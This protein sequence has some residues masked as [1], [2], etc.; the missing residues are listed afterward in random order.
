MTTFT[1]KLDATDDRIL[2]MGAGNTIMAD[3]GV[4]PRCIEELHRLFEFPEN[5]RLM[6]VGTTGLGIIDDLRQADRIVI[7]DAA[8]D[9]GHPAGTVLL[10]TPQE[11]AANQVMHSAHDMR[12]IDVFKAAAMMGLEFKSV[13]IVA[14]QVESLAQWVLELSEPV[15]AAVPIACA[16][17]LDQLQRMKITPLLREGETMPEIMA[18]AL[19]NFGPQP[20]DA[21]E[22]S[23]S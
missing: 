4:G 9:T 8:Q 21:L 13:V 17:A 18:D 22:D 20:E 23:N 3:E 12:L 14:V 2:V 16:A 7:L 10:V 6:D 1:E 5:V 11:L 15:A 19:E